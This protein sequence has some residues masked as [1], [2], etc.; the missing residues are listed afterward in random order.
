MLSSQLAF[1][2]KE[3]FIELL[4]PDDGPWEMEWFGAM[5]ANLSHLKMVCIPEGGDIVIPTIGSGALHL[6]K[7]L[8]E[9]V[10]FLKEEQYNKIDYSKRGIYKPEKRTLS[11]KIRF[12]WRNAFAKSRFQI[13]R[14]LWDNRFYFGNRRGKKG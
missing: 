7:W 11:Y 3:K 5:R 4:N 14:M 1:W 10:D 2:K 6:G 8:P 12:Q 13:I 9:M